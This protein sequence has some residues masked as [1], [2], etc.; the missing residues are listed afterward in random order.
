M[1]HESLRVQFWVWDQTG[2]YFGMPIKNFI[3]WSVT[4]LLFMAI[5]RALWRRDI[6]PA[7]LP[8]RVPLAVYAANV[9]FAMVL[10]AGVGL[11]VPI[12]SRGRARVAPR[13]VGG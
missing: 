7:S 1:A 11:W 3:G 8:M 12:L 5:S 2:P 13:F 9:A 6:D 4:G 10:S